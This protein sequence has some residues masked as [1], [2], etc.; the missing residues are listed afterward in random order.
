MS[1]MLNAI[2]AEKYRKN[3]KTLILLVPFYLILGKKMKDPFSI[4]Q[5]MEMLQVVGTFL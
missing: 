5:R 4:P 1:Y 2:L 3:I